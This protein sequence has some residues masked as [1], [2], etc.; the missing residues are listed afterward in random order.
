MKK[1]LKVD[2]N[3]TPC[4]VDIDDELYPNG[5]RKVPFSQMC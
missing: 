2:K 1:L 4:S 3:S 5:M